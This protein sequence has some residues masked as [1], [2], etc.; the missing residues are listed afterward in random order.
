MALKVSNISDFQ[1]Y[2][3]GVMGRANHHADN[4]NEII[5]ALVGGVVWKSNGR[6]QVKQYAGMPA[7]MLWME[8]GDQIYCFKFNHETDCIEVHL[9]T[10]NGEV[11]KEFNNST[12]L[13]EVKS[14]F[15]RL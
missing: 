3:E 7:N 9:N 10:H 1:Q 15:E 12:P 13:S 8:V 6:F 2:F 14:F 11:I 5:L 4:V